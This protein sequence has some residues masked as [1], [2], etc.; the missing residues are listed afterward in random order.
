MFIIWLIHNK[1]SYQTDCTNLTIFVTITN[2]GAKQFLSNMKENLKCNI[3]QN[4]IL[5]AVY[6]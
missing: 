5:S 4:S 1:Y 6:C 2:D 3:I